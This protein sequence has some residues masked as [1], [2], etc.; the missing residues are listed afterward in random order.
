MPVKTRSTTE[1]ERQTAAQK[2]SA[3]KQTTKKRQTISYAE[4]VQKDPVE[5]QVTSEEI[6]QKAPVTRS[7]TERKNQ[8]L[9]EVEVSGNSLRK[10]VE[11]S[12]PKEEIQER[13]DFAIKKVSESF[14]GIEI[15][16]KK[17]NAVLELV[18][19]K[20]RELYLKE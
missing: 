1:R 4:A 17:K 3:T 9:S 7:V 12:K 2:Q 14:I 20:L 15:S 19:N 13:I 18:Q 6:V 11:E 16:E 5:K 8:A 10:P